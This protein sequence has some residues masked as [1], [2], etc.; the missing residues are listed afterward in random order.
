MLSQKETPYLGF[1]IGQGHIQS[2]ADKVAAIRDYRL[3]RNQKQLR[4]FLG[5]ANYYQWFI[6]GFSESVAPL[7]DMTRGKVS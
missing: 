2:R 4:S 3:P 6:Q 7:T 5:F 1:H